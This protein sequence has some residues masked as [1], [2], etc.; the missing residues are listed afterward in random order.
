MQVRI[1]PGVP[2][3]MTYDQPCNV[4]GDIAGNYETLRLLLEKMPPGRTL[5]VG[6]IVDRGPRSKQVVQHFLDGR[7]DALKGNHEHMMVVHLRDQYKLYPDYDRGIWLI[8]GG[9]ETLRSYGCGADWVKLPYG[10]RDIWVDKPLPCGV[11]QDHIDFLDFLPLYKRLTYPGLRVHVSHAPFDTNLDPTRE[12]TKEFG[13]LWNRGWP[14]TSDEFDL[15]IH[16][17]NARFREYREPGSVD[18][19]SICID[20]SREKVLMGIHLPTLELFRQEYVD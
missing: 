11:P 14:Q 15:S 10:G 5:S 13:V 19:Y 12:A 9:M 17:H 16:G 3:F 18:R 20:D 1:L 7:G 4:I 2:I 8:N 6:D